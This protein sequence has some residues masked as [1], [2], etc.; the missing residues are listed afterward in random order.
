MKLSEILRAGKQRIETEGWC[1]GDELAINAQATGP[2][3][4]ATALL[5][6]EASVADVIGACLALKVAAGT[7]ILMGLSCWN[8]AP[9]RTLPE[10]LAAYDTAIAAA[11]AQEQAN[12]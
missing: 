11:E 9:T 8:D 10:V 2:F 1:Q 4:A 6:P 5:S 3:C 12:V 7:D